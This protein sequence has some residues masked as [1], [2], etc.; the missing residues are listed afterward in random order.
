[1]I[2]INVEHVESTAPSEFSGRQP[3]MKLDIESKAK[4]VL[5]FLFRDSFQ[6]P[7]ICVVK[8]GG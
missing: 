6:C 5:A 4:R 1:M 8:G 2:E 7:F 3:F